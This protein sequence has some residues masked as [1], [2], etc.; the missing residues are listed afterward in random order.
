MSRLASSLL[1]LLTLAPAPTAFAVTIH[2]ESA[3]GDLD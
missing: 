1:V 3:G 2:D